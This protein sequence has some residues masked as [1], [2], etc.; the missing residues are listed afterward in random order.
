VDICAAKEQGNN[1]LWATSLPGKYAPES[2]GRLIADW[3][4]NVLSEERQ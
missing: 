1:V 3:I 4:E 2:A